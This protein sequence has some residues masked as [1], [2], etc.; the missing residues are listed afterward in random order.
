MG[1]PINSPMDDIVKAE[2]E[3]DAN[4]QITIAN[5]IRG[6]IADPELEYKRKEDAMR[7]VDAENWITQLTQEGFYHDG[8]SPVIGA[9]VGVVG[10][11]DPL[12]QKQA[13]NDFYLVN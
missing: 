5:I 4:K 12:E 2:N 1:L 8:T 13:V 9:K 11:L 6:T 7:I 3:A 10:V